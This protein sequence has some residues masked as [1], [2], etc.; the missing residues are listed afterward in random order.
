MSVY[1]HH[2][3]PLRYPGGKSRIAGF[4]EDIILLNNLENCTMYEL[5]AGGA[6]ASLTALFSGVCSKIVLN[7]LDPHIYNFWLSLLEKTD[8]FV[9]L[10]EDIEVDIATWEKQKEIYLNHQN[11]STLEVGFSTFYLNRCNR[12]GILQAGPIGG[13]DQ[14]GNYKIDVRF[15]KKNLIDRIQLIASKKDCIEIRNEESIVLLENIMNHDGQ[16]SFVFLD[17]PYYV[18]GEN[19]YLNSYQDSDHLALSKL[20]DLNRNANWFL[21]YDNAERIKELYSTFKTAYL[22]MTYTLQSKVKSKEIMVFSENLFLP[23]QLRIGSK[24][25]ELA[26]I[27]L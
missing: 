26:M 25:E 1:L 27:N 10:I 20:L 7:D 15:N 19:L 21:T 6:G 24:S 5:Y 4:I 12:S 9:Q 11:Y 3:S 14:T 17:P 8:E 18:Q 22:P 23:K 2:L 16:A 13:K